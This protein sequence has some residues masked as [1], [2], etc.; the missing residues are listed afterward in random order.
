MQATEVSRFV[1]SGLQ[2]AT[3][4]R[5]PQIAG[6]IPQSVVF[7]I[8]YVL[9]SQYSL[10][11]RQAAAVVDAVT[12]FPGMKIVDDCPWKRVLEL[13]PDP[14]SGLTDATIVALASRIDTTPLRRSIGSSRTSSKGSASTRVFEERSRANQQ[15]IVTL[16]PVTPE[17]A[18]SSLVG[19][20]NRNTNFL[21]CLGFLRMPMWAVRGLPHKSGWW[22]PARSASNSS[23]SEC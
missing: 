3:I 17:V 13:W 15:H 6:V 11:S 14:L 22:I 2:Q 18:G 23:H 19:P 1:W 12:K 7:E 21:S 4:S 10:T 16:R 9:Q 5:D 8:V 20:A